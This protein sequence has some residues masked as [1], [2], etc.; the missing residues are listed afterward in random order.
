MKFHWSRA[1]NVNHDELNYC[2]WRFGFP[3]GWSSTSICVLPISRLVLLFFLALRPLLLFPASFLQTAC[4]CP[5]LSLLLASI[6][7]PPTDAPPPL[8]AYLF[9]SPSVPLALPSC[10]SLPLR[11]VS[12]LPLCLSLCLYASKSLCMCVCVSVSLSPPP[13]ILLNTFLLFCPSVRL[14]VSPVSFSHPLSRLSGKCP[15]TVRMLKFV[16]LHLQGK[17]RFLTYSNLC[18]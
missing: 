9:L 5:F 12:S 1:L 14:P 18:N 16:L 7:P 4:F 2:Q 10:L 17:H 6:P 15:F 11:S 13:S 3:L 8:L